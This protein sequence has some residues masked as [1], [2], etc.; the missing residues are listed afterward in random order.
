MTMNSARLATYWDIGDAA[1]VIDFLDLLRDA[2]L[3][4]PYGDQITQIHREAYYDRFEDP[5]QCELE[6]DDDIPS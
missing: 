6:F 2:L 1:T 3:W 4:E 5:N